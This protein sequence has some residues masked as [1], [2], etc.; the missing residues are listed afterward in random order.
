MKSSK[1]GREKINC[2][3]RLLYQAKTPFRNEGEIDT[4]RKSKIER[5]HHH[6]TSLVIN[7]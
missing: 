5:I 7:A 6:Q 4:L 2:Q 3:Q 1:T